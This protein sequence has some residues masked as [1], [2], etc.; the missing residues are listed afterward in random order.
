LESVL[1]VAGQQRR[2]QKS[3]PKS[4]RIFLRLATGAVVGYGLYGVVWVNATPIIANAT[5]GEA[6]VF[7]LS[8]VGG[9]ADLEFPRTPN[10]DESL[11]SSNPFTFTL[12]MQ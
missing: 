3:D 10:G 4:K 6:L 1:T 5:A 12:R 8:I 9:F 11:E 2:E 7:G